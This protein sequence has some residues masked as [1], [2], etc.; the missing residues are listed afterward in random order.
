MDLQRF[1]SQF[2]FVSTAECRRMVIAGCV[3]IDGRIIRHADLNKPASVFAK[4]GSVVKIG[5]RLSHE[6]KEEH[7]R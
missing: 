3:T 1:L 5:K 6:V 4:V 2:S 7:F